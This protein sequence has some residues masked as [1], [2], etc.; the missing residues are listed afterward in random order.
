MSNLP[1]PAV[2]EL[3]QCLTDNIPF[4]GES[5]REVNGK[6]LPRLQWRKDGTLNR[7]DKGLALDIILF[8]EKFEEDQLAQSLIRV[9]KKDQYLLK[10]RGLI[11]KHTYVSGLTFAEQTW[12]ADDHLNHLHIDWFDYSLYAATGKTDI[13]WPPEASTAGFSIL[14][15][16]DLSY[17]YTCWLSNVSPDI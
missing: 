3:M 9:F 10:W 1:C 13:P 5:Y 4:L 15:G 7:H 6:Y 8:S 2:Q 12:D 16:F 17:I 14:L 11:F